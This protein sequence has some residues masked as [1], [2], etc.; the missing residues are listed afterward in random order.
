MF[1]Y[2]E[3]DNKAKRSIIEAWD[4]RRYLILSE[5]EITDFF[6]DCIE[7]TKEVLTSLPKEII[8]EIEALGVQ[9]QS[10]TDMPRITYNRYS[11]YHEALGSYLLYQH[12][13][14]PTIWERDEKGDTTHTAEESVVFNHNGESILWQIQF[15]KR[16]H[17]KTIEFSIA[18]SGIEVPM[19]TQRDLIALGKIRTHRPP[20]ETYVACGE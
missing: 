16:I 9:P 11:G 4:M 1:D 17:G 6:L 14:S 2:T 5:E 8:P 13:L 10:Y 18:F 7:C 3:V 19:E 12:N 20:P 15:S